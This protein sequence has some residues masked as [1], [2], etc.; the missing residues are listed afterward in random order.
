MAAFMFLAVKRKDR[1]SHTA[2]GLLVLAQND[3]QAVK[4]QFDDWEKDM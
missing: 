3:P 2:L 4:K 1:E